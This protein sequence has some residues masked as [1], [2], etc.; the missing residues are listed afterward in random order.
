M[1]KLIVAFD[2]KRGIGKNNSIPW[3][4]KEDLKH[5]AKLTTGNNK[6]AIV[7]GRKTYESIG[8]ILP[9]R[10]NIIISNSLENN[11]VINDIHQLSI[12]CS[13]YDFE[14]IW[15]IGGESIYNY[16]ID[17]NLISEIF[18]TE[19]NKNYNCDTFFPLLDD[20]LWVKSVY[21]KS[22][23]SNYNFYKY[24]YKYYTS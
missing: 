12:Y 18:S 4:L 21:K 23:N 7:M 11:N 15:I 10:H 2:K 16:F 6:N 9:H 13:N 19:I 20:K 5:F 3:I 8:R 14:H 1:Y 22:N 17:N 24:T